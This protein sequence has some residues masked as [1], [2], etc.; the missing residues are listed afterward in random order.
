MK[1]CILGAGGFLGHT[2]AQELQQRGHFVVMLDLAYQDFGH[3]ALDPTMLSKIKGSILCRNDL[4]QAL[5]DCDACFHLASYG[6]VGGASLNREKTMLVNVTGTELIIE[7][8]IRSGVKRIVYASTLCVVWSGEHEFPTPY[9]ESKCLAEKMVLQANG[10]RGLQ[11]CALRPR[12]IYGPG[13]MRATGR[14]VD[15]CQQGLVVE[16]SGYGKPCVTQYSSGE[17]VIN[18]MILAEERL[19]QENAACAGKAYNIV[20]D[21]PPV[22]AFKF[23]DPLV[24]GGTGVSPLVV[25]VPYWF[26]YGLA[27]VLE[28]LYYLVGIEPMYTRLEVNYMA[29]TNTFS[30]ENARRDLGSETIVFFEVDGA[31]VAIAFF[32]SYVLR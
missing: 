17:N 18:A 1:A 7:E 3:I 10:T 29:V 22:A 24:R 19:R 16:W 27:M 30:I 11:A 32:Q 6:T 2:L 23:W 28:W 9:A 5:F 12:G 15:F 20:D 25:T 14:I 4:S 8:C 31:V 21:G 13:E 26:A